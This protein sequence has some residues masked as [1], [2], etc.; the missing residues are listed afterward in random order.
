MQVVSI[1]LCWIVVKDLKKALKYYTEVV[2]LKLIE[3]NEHYHW[4]ELQG[5]QGGARLGIAQ[6][7]DMEEVKPGQNAVVTY[8]VEEIGIALEEMKKKGANCV[9]S[10][11]E[12]PGHVKMQTMKDDDG[13]H[14]Q[15]VQLLD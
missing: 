5:Y 14:F 8:R 9:G 15:I 13:N 12:I 2:G 6:D 11:I 1:D 4:A 7:S 3:H 10:P